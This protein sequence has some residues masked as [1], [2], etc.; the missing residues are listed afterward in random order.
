M[1]L[2]L[3]ISL[4][5]ITLFSYI[6]LFKRDVSTPCVYF[7]LSFSVA[8]T[9]LWLLYDINEYNDLHENTVFF[10]LISTCSLVFGSLIIKKRV[11]NKKV[12]QQR[13]RISSF[14]LVL[15]LICQF[16]DVVLTIALLNSHYGRCSISENLYA[17]TLAIK[18]FSSETPL[19]LPIFL[20]FKDVI[21]Y[22]LIYALAYYS[23]FFLINHKKY[24]KEL[25]LSVINFFFILFFSLLSSGR[26]QIIAGII[27]FSYFYFVQ[28]Q[29]S[30][31]S[32]FKPAFS[33]LFIF[34]VFLFSF[35]FLG[36]SV[37][38]D[39]LKN[40][41]ISDT[42]FIYCGA[43]ILA[44]DRYINSNHKIKTILPMGA[45]F[46]SYASYLN[47]KFGIFGNLKALTKSEFSKIVYFDN[48]K[49]RGLGNL[50]TA[51][52]IYFIDFGFWGSIF[53][54]FIIGFLIQF[55]RNIAINKQFYEGV[56]LWKVLILG[57][58]IY[59]IS[60]SFF[61]EQFFIAFF[62]ILTH[63]FWIAFIIICLFLTRKFILFNRTFK[64]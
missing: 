37:G 48:I 39:Y 15:I 55:I 28:L 17:H 24:K 14:G 12:L 36:Q 32:L 49:N 4:W 63:T 5:L 11:S 6:F 62:S 53:L 41:Q 33:V 7:L 20:G 1:L 43:E 42:I 26:L 23:S 16:L 54:C 52:Y 13:V 45:T 10:I 29:F 51:L 57:D 34:F 60:L 44:L 46:N 40:R 2:F 50:K 38:R 59:T 64:I 27:S 22:Y 56:L 3:V 9:V 18:G 30:R 8:S 31:K 58:I 21:K 61:T 19:K 25:F 47:R 35:N